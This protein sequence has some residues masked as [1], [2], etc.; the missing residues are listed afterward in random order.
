MTRREFVGTAA[1]AATGIGFGVDAFG[2]PV[3]NLR[4]G[5][6]TD[7]HLHHPAAISYFERALKLFRAEDVDAVLIAG[8]LFTWGLTSQLEDVAKTWFR[9]F[10]GDIG[11]NG[12][13]IERLF[14]TGNHD[15][16]DWRTSQFKDFDDLKKR[17]FLLNREA[18]WERLW[19][20]KYEKIRIR[21]VKGY[22]FVLRHWLGRPLDLMGHKIPSEPEVLP[23]FLASHGEELKTLG[24]PFF[25][26]QHEPID[27]TVNATWV[28]D[29]FHWDNGQTGRG[30]KE[31]DLLGNFPNAVVL[32]G[33]S[34]DSLTDEMSIWQG[35][36]TAVNCSSGTGYIFNA[37]GRVNGFNGEDFSREPPLEMAAFDHRV[38]QG[39]IMDVFDGEIVFRRLDTYYN[40]ELGAPWVVPLFAGGATVPSSGT[41]KFDFRARKLASKPPT[42]AADAKVSVSYVPE[43]YARKVGHPNCVADKSSAH[44]Q[45]RVSFPSITTK[46]SPSRA[47]DF[48]VR[49]EHMTGNVMTC[50]KECRVYSPNWCSAESRD[51]VPCS[52]DFNY[53]ALPRNCR[54]RIRFVVTPFDCWGNAGRP[55]MSEWMKTDDIASSRMTERPGASK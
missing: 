31:K 17:C 47:V 49:C 45:L 50:E 9:V 32:T 3:S 10:P 24:K 52:C 36:F 7:I 8:D 16:V 53:A 13:K 42:F 29:G 14:I 30:L 43:G 18:V 19:G 27:E 5:I 26:V 38:C 21:R 23:D 39:L 22:T 48:S 28:L 40:E 6:L 44:P 51:V 1:M 2:V 55:I 35:K 25:Y 54:G 20:E 46:T 37:P 15:E 11:L 34:H 4:V 12:K 33:H 41:P